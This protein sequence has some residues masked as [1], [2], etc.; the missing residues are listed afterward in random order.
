MKRNDMK[1][2]FL[3]TAYQDFEWLKRTVDIYRAGVNCYIHVDKRAHIPKEIMQWAEA[4]GG[5]GTS[6]FQI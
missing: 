2:V 4:S 3:I 6:L 5:G 1:Q